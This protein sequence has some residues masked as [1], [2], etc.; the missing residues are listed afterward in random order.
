[1]TNSSIA[2]APYD[3]IGPAVQVMNEAGVGMTTS[4]RGIE[5]TIR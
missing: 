2:S 3:Q 4:G 5:A 1:M